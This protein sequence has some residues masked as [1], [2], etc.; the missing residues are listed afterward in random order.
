MSDT[1]GFIEEVTEEVRRDQLYAYLKKYGW[2]AILAVLLVVGGASYNEYRKAQQ[3]AEAEA[4]GDRLLEAL[5][6]N[7]GRARSVALSEIPLTGGSR[8]A[9]V[10]MISAAE[11][12]SQE[13]ITQAVEK[14]DALA[15]NTEVPEIYRQLAGFKAMLM[16][17]ETLTPAERANGFAAFDTPG[18]PMR[19]LAAEQLA[20]I[21][22][23]Q[24]DRDAALARLQ[25]ILSDAE[26]SSGLQQ[27]AMQVI[28]ALGGEPEMPQA[29]QSS[30]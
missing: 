13:D 29:F 9:V 6:M 21:A 23:E 8:D 10:A 16:Q 1:D 4:L 27:R 5:T 26:A 2:I 14:L 24:G 17:A 20:L 28:V 30:N 11:L 15:V 18:H 7:D 19:L 12:A 3:Q 22:I 25:G